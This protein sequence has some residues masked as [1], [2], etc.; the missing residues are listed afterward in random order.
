MESSIKSKFENMK[1]LPDHSCDYSNQPSVYPYPP[2][3]HAEH[4]DDYN[5]SYYHPSDYQNH[6]DHPGDYSDYRDDYPRLSKS[7]FY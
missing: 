6:P 7:D 2:R 3:D 1:T 4:P 5:K